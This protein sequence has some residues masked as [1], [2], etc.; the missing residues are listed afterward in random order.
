VCSFHN[1][2]RFR[3]NRSSPPDTHLQCAARR[4][5]KPMPCSAL[6]V[7]AG[8][9][10]RS[11]TV[12]DRR[13]VFSMGLVLAL[14]AACSGDTETP[15]RQLQIPVGRQLQISVTVEAKAKVIALLTEIAS[16]KQMERRAAA[17]GLDELQGRKVTYF[18]FSWD[19]SEPA[20]TITDL[21]DPAELEINV[22]YKR[23]PELVDEIVDKFLK[24]SRTIQGA[25]LIKD[26]RRK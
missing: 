13:A 25:T 12:A 9:L 10:R 6:P 8:Q 3:L 14:Q 19:P 1:L 23:A 22:Y 17:P 18:W 20:L 7:R 4:V 5:D 11:V 16:A 15:G 26:E 21:L 2:C 24:D